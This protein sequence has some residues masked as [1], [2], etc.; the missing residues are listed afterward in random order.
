MCHPASTA[1][2]TPEFFPCWDA[3]RC[4]VRLST[5]LRLRRW[6]PAEAR[7]EDCGE[8]RCAVKVGRG[9]SPLH[10]STCTTQHQPGTTPDTSEQLPRALPAAWA[11]SCVG[12]LQRSLAGPALPR[13]LPCTISICASL[14]SISAAVLAPDIACS[15][16]GG[17]CCCDL[18]AIR[19]R[20]IYSSIVCANARGAAPKCPCTVGRN[21]RRGHLSNES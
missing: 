3:R 6:G 8:R 15:V 9:S 2:F 13:H 10:L 5:C 21:R 19:G 14:A 1:T 11:V 18:S 7:A 4:A 17:P 16:A 20:N 12:A